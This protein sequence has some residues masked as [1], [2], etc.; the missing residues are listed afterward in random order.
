M[1]TIGERLKLLVEAEKLNLFSFSKRLGVSNTAITKIAKGDSKPGFE[2]IDAILK[3][4]PNLNTDWLINGTGEMFKQAKAETVDNSYLM[5][6]LAKLEGEFKHQLA[7]KDQQINKLLD[8][9]GKLE[10][11]ENTTCGRLATLWPENG[12]ITA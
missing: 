1:T 8:L 7:M 3:E 11:S 2:I 4:F 12:S 10:V 5:D 9:L 6:F